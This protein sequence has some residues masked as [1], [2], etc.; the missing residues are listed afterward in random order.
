FISYHRY[1]H[2]LKW[3]TLSLF[4]YVAVVLVVNVD[5]AAAAK[6]LV[7]PRIAGAQAI[8]T[9]VAIFGTTISPYLF[10]WQAAQEVEEVEDH[11]GARPLNEAPE[12]APGEIRRMRVDT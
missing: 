3:L 5:W 8:A 6:G 10:F 9:G 2:V 12:Q 1:A 7:V 11:D 4:A